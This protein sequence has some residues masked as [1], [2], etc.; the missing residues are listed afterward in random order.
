[1]VT[2]I[3]ILPYDLSNYIFNLVKLKD[4][5]ETNCKQLED[6]SIYKKYFYDMVYSQSEYRQ[7]NLRNVI[8]GHLR[9]NTID[10]LINYKECLYF[11]SISFFQN[12]KSRL[13]IHQQSYYFL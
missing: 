10:I 12:Y 9:Y 8:A 4:I 1:M 3:D 2:W 7:M 13:L 5:K 11:G 6:I